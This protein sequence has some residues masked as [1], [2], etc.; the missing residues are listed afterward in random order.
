MASETFWIYEGN[1]VTTESGTIRK[2]PDPISVNVSCL[3]HRL[4]DELDVLHK[5]QQGTTLFQFGWKY[6]P[7]KS[8]QFT[9]MPATVQQVNA[10]TV[11]QLRHPGTPPCLLYPDYLL[12]L[13]SLYLRTS[14]CTPW[15]AT[16]PTSPTGLATIAVGKRP[17]RGSYLVEMRF[18]ATRHVVK[19]RTCVFRR[20]PATMD[21]VRI[22]LP[23]CR[24]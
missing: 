16:T 12:F 22:L 3:R 1:G 17:P 18:L 8:V 9:L 21:N 4:A 13:S 7:C 2:R 5:Y 14:S 10:C 15:Q 20:G 6:L 23:F 24:Q 19:A 11:T